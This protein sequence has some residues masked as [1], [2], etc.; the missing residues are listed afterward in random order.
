MPG[1][2][3]AAVFDGAAFRRVGPRVAAGAWDFTLHFTGDISEPG[4]AHW[5]QIPFGLDDVYRGARCCLWGS[6]ASPSILA[7]WGAEF[8][9]RGGA[10]MP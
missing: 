1:D 9:G 8:S 5:L 4:Q 2:G 3:R 10:K 6:A 7:F